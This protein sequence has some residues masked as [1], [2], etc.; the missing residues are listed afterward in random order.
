MIV[1][2]EDRPGSILELLTLIYNHGINISHIRSKPSVFNGIG[3]PT[4]DIYLDLE[5]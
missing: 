3:I 2:I 1:N 4:G 5:C